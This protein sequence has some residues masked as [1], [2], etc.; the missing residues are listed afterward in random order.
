[1]PFTGYTVV[2]TDYQAYHLAIATKG[3]TMYLW[4]AIT[5]LFTGSLTI[6]LSSL[7]FPPAFISHVTVLLLTTL[8]S[9]CPAKQLI[10]A[11]ISL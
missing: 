3:S 10:E 8:S 6:Y 4:T 11:F 2:R 9:T 1:M 7:I 5:P